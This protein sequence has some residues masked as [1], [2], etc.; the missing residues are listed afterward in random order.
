[1][2]RIPV[3]FLA[4]ALS[5]V[6]LFG[7]LAVRAIATAQ[8]GPLTVSDATGAYAIL[9][10]ETGAKGYGIQ[11]TSVSGNGVIG[12]SA[13]AKKA[14]VL[15][16]NTAGGPGVAGEATT[17][18]G[19]VG[20]TKAA[21][22]KNAQYEGVQGV[23]QSASGQ[24]RGVVGSS[25]HGVG[26]WGTISNSNDT[27]PSIGVVGIGP[28]TGVL[29]KGG[30]AGVEA[31]SSNV[32]APAL[33]MQAKSSGSAP[34]FWSLLPSGQLTGLLTSAGNLT[35]GGNLTQDNAVR[36]VVRGNGSPRVSYASQSTAPAIEDTGEGRIALGAGYVPIDPALTSTLDPRAPYLVLLTP[37]GDCRGLYVTNKTP[38][39]F[40]VRELMNGRSNVAFTYRL[41]GRPAGGN[42]DRLP[43]Y[44]ETL[45]R[46][47]LPASPL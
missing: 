31:E 33:L 38:R 14:G 23:D 12:N 18:A 39:G 16:G 41:V 19:V 32:G 29:G 27:F 22:G 20:T 44:T 24:Q 30:I 3:S 46:V 47:T 13:N 11:G 21:S 2:L 10:Q 8:P 34:A 36:M 26:V 17:S 35:I 25:P 45:H 43:L 6:L 9:G 15:G 28:A 37:E 40:T 7:G 5:A 1:M 4:V 42:A